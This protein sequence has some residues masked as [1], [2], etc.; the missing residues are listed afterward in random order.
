MAD[1]L[2]HNW[3]NG[4]VS[5]VTGASSGIGLE[6]ALALGKAGAKVGVN[7]HKNREGA[8][9]AV[10]GIVAAGG[11]A[12]AIQADVSRAADVERMYAELAVAFGNRVD[13]LVCNAG[14]WMDRCSIVDCS[15]ETWDRMFTVNARS[16]FLCCRMA[17]RRM[18]DQGDGAI[19]NIGSVAGHT[20]SGES[21]VPYAAAKAAVHTFTRGLAR[22]L[23]PHGIRV[24]AVAPGV[25]ETPMLE[26][27]VAPEI[28]DKIISVIPL[29]RFGQ[30]RE[31]APLVLSLLSPDCSYV[32]GTIIEVDG[33][34]VM[35]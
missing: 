13:M 8:D 18:I 4:R 7:Y 21:A 15:D 10:Q 2:F 28:R 33:G 6:I 9:K 23:G 11:Q 20:G 25:I 22:E 32:T 26:G 17:A 31:I 27:R 5:L 34:L 1:T 14:S 29:L 24:N 35:R 16:V 30:P 3:F 12:V 19:V